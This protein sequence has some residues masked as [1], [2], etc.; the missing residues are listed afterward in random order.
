M[1]KGSKLMAMGKAYNKLYPLKSFEK[2]LIKHD[3]KV[4]LSSMSPKPL[5]TLF[6]LKN[7]IDRIL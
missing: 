5:T 1:Q 7:S 2:C 4:N 3:L 6:S